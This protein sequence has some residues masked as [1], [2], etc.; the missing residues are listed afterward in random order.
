MVKKRSKVKWHLWIL[1]LIVTGFSW[2]AVFTGLV[3]NDPMAYGLTSVQLMFWG[4]P[5]VTLL[6]MIMPEIIEE[7]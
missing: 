5:V 2:Y 4:P 1:A 6:A 3:P 7:D